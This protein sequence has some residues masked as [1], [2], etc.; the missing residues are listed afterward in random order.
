[1]PVASYRTLREMLE[2][3]GVGDD[4]PVR[5]SA[6]KALGSDQGLSSS[7]TFR[8]P[9]LWLQ[10]QRALP[11]IE[12]TRDLNDQSRLDNRYPMSRHR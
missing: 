10:R 6:A 3:L 11:Y 4:C 9:P 5:L 2:R 12:L 7:F 8:T 1:M